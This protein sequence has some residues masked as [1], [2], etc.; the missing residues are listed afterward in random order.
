METILKN[1]AVP[2]GEGRLPPVGFANDRSA[3]RRNDNF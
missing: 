3:A 1:I 2:S